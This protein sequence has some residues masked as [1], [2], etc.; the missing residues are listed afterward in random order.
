M[1]A[2]I[3]CKALESGRVL[4]LRY[5]GYFRRVEV[6]AVGETR[7]GNEIMRVWQIGGGSVSNEPIGWK[8]LRLEDATNASISADRS[9]APR[10]G[11]R[12]DDPAMTTMYCQL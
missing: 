11:Y 1:W 3:A 4:E 5:D 8:L 12:R 6:H 7:D 10:K 2:S 9:A